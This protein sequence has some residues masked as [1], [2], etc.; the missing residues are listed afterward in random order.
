MRAVGWY[1]KIEITHLLVS[2]HWQFGNAPVAGIE[3]QWHFMSL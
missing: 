2:F 1:F 3:Q